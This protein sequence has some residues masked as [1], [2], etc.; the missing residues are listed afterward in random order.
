M[1][2]KSQTAIP[3]EGSTHRAPIN[4]FRTSE[5]V[6]PSSL[7]ISSFVIHHWYYSLL[8]LVTYVSVFLFWKQF[9]SRVGFVVGGVAAVTLLTVGLAWAWR[10]KYFVNRIDLC[11]HGYIIADLCMESVLFEVLQL[12]NNAQVTAGLASQFHHNNNYIL[13]TI[14]LATLIG[15]YRYYAL[16]RANV[17]NQPSSALT[18]TTADTH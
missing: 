11:L 16:R 12:F 14:T 2:N 15:G 13:C 7:G 10:R 4:S 5:F 9:P 8:M 18:G 17:P 3:N 6:I 1:T